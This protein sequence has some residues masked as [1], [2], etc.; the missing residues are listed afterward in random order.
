MSRI[1]ILEAIRQGSVGGGET[2]VFDLSTRLDKNHFEPIVLSFTD[3]PMVDN[4]RASKIETHVIHSHFPFDPRVIRA[5]S[6]LLQ[7]QK[8]DIVHAHGTRAASNVWLP[9]SRNQLPLIYT[10]HGWSFNDN[11]S[12]FVKFVR[13]RAEQ[14]ITARARVNICVSESNRQTGNNAIPGFKG[15]VINNGVSFE[16][17]SP[18]LDASS[19]IAELGKQPGE[20]WV[21][22][23]AR[24]TR[25]KDPIT[26]LKAFKRANEINPL[27]KLL[28]VGDGDMRQ[29]VSQTIHSYK[30]QSVVKLLPFRKDVPELLRAIDIYC[31][32]SL[33]EGLPIGLLEAM[34]ME[35][36]VIATR[37]DGTKEIVSAETGVLIEKQN[38]SDL[39]SAIVALAQNQAMR[40]KLGHKAR[41]LVE[42][43]F[44]LEQMV[45]KTEECYKAVN[46]EVKRQKG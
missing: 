7:D 6:S 43:N 40:N 38:P 33:W 34:L 2:H 8:I 42:T 19:V 16:K 46:L 17:F 3:G 21:G 13:T 28:I 11:Q 15:I 27:L 20:I 31:L 22:M 37:V 1:R 44:S 36:A 29:E 39:A 23:I 41:A 26:L 18:L 10:I 4:L 24:L 5:V 32:P 30:L 25:Q 14:F 35:K 9:T 12:R 45:S